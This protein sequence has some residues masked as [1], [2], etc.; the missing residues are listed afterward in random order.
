[1]EHSKETVVHK[2]DESLELTMSKKTVVHKA[3]ESPELDHG[4]ENGCS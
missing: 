1:M 3:D 4:Q 2:A